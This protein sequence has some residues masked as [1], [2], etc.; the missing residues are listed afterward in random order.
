M[1]KQ[2]RCGQVALLGQLAAHFVFLWVVISPHPVASRG[3]VWTHSLLNLLLG[4][5][6]PP[7]VVQL[8][9]KYL[10]AQKHWLKGVGVLVV[11]GSWVMWV[12][13][14]PKSS[15]NDAGPTGGTGLA[16]TAGSVGGAD[17]PGDADIASGA[18]DL[19]GGVDLAPGTCGKSA[20][21]NRMIMVGGEDSRT[22]G[23]R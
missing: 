9:L 1:K 10:W 13:L 8:L 22:G 16:V 17:P 21:S 2:H 11:R 15:I 12:Y 6:N 5:G 23:R 3:E 7:E 4:H 14:P 20:S 19:A 18:A